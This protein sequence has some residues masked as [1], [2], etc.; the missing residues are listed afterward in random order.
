MDEKNSKILQHWRGGFVILSLIV[1]DMDHMV[2]ILFCVCV[3]VSVN[4]ANANT[5]EIITFF[6]LLKKRMIPCNVMNIYFAAAAA[7]IYVLIRLIVF[8]F[9]HCA[10][11]MNEIIENNF[12]N[13]K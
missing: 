6:F 11:I 3:C 7:A 8:L 13:S 5:Q 1:I 4:I 12:L 9:L 10:G 2:L